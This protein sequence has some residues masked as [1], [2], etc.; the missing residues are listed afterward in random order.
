MC[1]YRSRSLVCPFGHSHIFFS[2]SLSRVSFYLSSFRFHTL[3]W[4]HIQIWKITNPKFNR[5]IYKNQNVLRKSSQ[6]VMRKSLN[7]QTIHNN[8]NC[9]WKTA[10][11]KI[12]RR[13]Q[14]KTVDICRFF[15]L[16]IKF[17]LLWKK[18]KQNATYT[19]EIIVWANMT[20]MSK[21]SFHCTTEIVWVCDWYV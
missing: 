7:T 13:T 3:L 11:L 18:E 16:I 12:K 4:L 8:K 14:K 9:N 10:L 20:K 2:L 19:I 5:T 6:L 1:L 15:L 17:L 21:C